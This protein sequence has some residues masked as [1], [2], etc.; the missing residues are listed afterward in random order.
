MD[1]NW[2]IAGRDGK[3]GQYDGHDLLWTTAAPL[4]TMANAFPTK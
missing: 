3:A 2:D 1:R 4:A